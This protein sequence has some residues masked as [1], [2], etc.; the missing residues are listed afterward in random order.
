MVTSVYRYILEAILEVTTHT[1][2]KHKEYTVCGELTATRLDELMKTRYDKLFFSR[3]LTEQHGTLLGIAICRF[4]LFVSHFIP[5]KEH[6][7]CQTL[8]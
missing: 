2:T 6:V 4:S 5:P 1:L 7:H 3:M 8:S